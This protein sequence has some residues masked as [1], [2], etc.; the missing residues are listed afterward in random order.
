MKRMRH[1]TRARGLLLALALGGG[2][3][4]A[5]EA[6]DR[7]ESAEGLRGLEIDEPWPAPAFTLDDTAGEPFDFRSETSGRLSLVFFG[8]T[9]CPDIC[10]VQMSI[11]DAALADLAYR[12]RQRIRVLFVTTDPERDT[13]ERL[14]AWLDRFDPSFVGLHGGV[15]RVNEILAG[16]RLPA[17]VIEPPRAG[18]EGSAE[19]HGDDGADGGSYYVGHATPVVAVTGDGRIRA[20]YPSG[21]RQ[22][23]WRHDLP[24]LLAM[25]AAAAGGEPGES[26]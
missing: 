3:S 1:V 12:E 9:H 13:P 26:E 15:D 4:P 6:I 20:L 2:C 23:D 5:E 22:A 25:N 10:P 18:G 11:L 14:R 16:F 24:L 19:A 21:V 17:S 7:T 8:Y